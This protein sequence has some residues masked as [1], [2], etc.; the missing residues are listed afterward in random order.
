MFARL[1]LTALF[2]ACVGCGQSI[3]GIEDTGNSSNLPE[4]QGTP[5][6]PDT[7]NPPAPGDPN[8]PGNP[9]PNDPSDPQ[10]P[11]DPSDPQDLNGPADP[12]N[13]IPPEDVIPP[14]AQ[15]C[16]VWQDCGP[17]FDDL[18]SGLECQSNQ[19][20]C[21]PA[22]Q[23]ATTCANAGA[24]WIEEEC[25]C[26]FASQARP[27]Q[28]PSENCWW[29]WYDEPCEGDTWIDTSHYRDECY[30]DSFQEREVCNAVW[31]EEGY[32]ENGTCDTGYWL[33]YCR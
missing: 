22:G 29:H 21:D 17:H 1:A 23:W 2:T 9:D 33:E 24:F 20:V 6:T 19:C 3:G 25:F 26:Q 28:T 15:T 10:P 27:A 18:N 4:N 5:N 31:V 13:E 7:P 12:P 8:D 16:T 14:D 11:N 30:Y 32:W